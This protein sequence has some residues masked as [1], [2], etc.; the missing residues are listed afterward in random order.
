MWQI[1]ISRMST[2]S[3]FILAAAAGSA[4][5]LIG[6]PAFAASDNTTPGRIRIFGTG[7]GITPN[8]TTVQRDAN[9]QIIAYPTTNGTPSPNTPPAPPQSLYIPNST[10]PFYTNTTG[11]PGTST[12]NAGAKGVASFDSSITYRWGTA[13]PNNTA[14]SPAFGTF[15]GNPTYSYVVQ[16]TY[17]VTKTGIYNFET[18]LSGDNRVTVYLGGTPQAT[19]A[20]FTTGTN[21]TNP[22][23][24]TIQNGNLLGST[25]AGPVGFYKITANNISL[26]AGSN[27]T[28]NYLVSDFANA[29]YGGNGLLVSTTFFSEAPVPGPVPALGACAFFA[30]S[31]K[32]RRRI[33]SV[34]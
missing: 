14:T 30:Y 1:R 32:L 10:L 20:P 18:N 22:Y 21:F 23:G 26:T 31:R 3:K 17:N 19:T 28:L 2:L 34:A 15:T 25:T 6:L 27:F 13:N 11:T 12:T 7:E 29:N 33:K 8:S 5:C 4:T 16:T 24:F 9:W